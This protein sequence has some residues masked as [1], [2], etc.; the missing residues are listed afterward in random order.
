MLPRPASS[1]S[2]AL[3]QFM[4]LHRTIGN[5]AVG[6]LI[7]R[8]ETPNR[9]SGVIQAKLTINKPNDFYEQEADRVAEQVMRMPEATVQAKSA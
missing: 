9:K 6:R 1:V 5:Q 4:T 8:S 3:S 2:S 7:Q